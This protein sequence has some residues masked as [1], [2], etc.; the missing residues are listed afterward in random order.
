MSRR[1]RILQLKST[2]PHVLPSLLLCDF[3]DLKSECHRLEEAGIQ[4]LHLDVMDGQFVPNLT[5]GMPIVE[6]LRRHTQLPLDVHLMIANPEKYI[7]QF[8]ESGADAITF[9][10][11]ACDN[12]RPVLEKIRTLGAASGIVVNPKTP[13]SKIESC[14][15]LCDIVLIMSVEAGFGGQSFQPST[16]ERLVEARTMFGPDVLLEVDGG[17]NKST[18]IECVQNGAELLV[19]GSAIFRQSDYRTAV[20][21]LN[22]L[23]ASSTQSS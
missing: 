23:A 21:D 16:L 19:A 4:C 5:Y 18:I 6:G 22:D 7:E 20:S 12:P 13:L 8:Y 1:E 11:E 10:I 15:G 9:H 17:V 2:G 3:G 14:V